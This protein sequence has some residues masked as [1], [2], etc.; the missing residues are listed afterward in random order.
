MSSC[1]TTSTPADPNIKL[2]KPSEEKSIN[3]KPYQ[4]AIGSLMYLMLA[5]RPDITAALTKLSQFAT[6]Y[7]ITHWTAL[8]RIFRYIKGT[9][10]YALTLGGLSGRNGNEIVLSGS[11]DADWAGDAD[12]RRSTTGYIFLLNNHV[13]SWQTH[14]Q[15]SVATSSTQAEYQALSSATKEAIWLRSLLAELDFKQANPTA[16]QQDNQSAIAL[17]NNPTNHKRTKHIDIAHHFVRECKEEKKITL[18]YCPTQNIIAD[19]MTKPLTREKFERCRGN[20]GIMG[21]VE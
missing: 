11:C 9:Q 2:T 8:K 6:S 19:V 7:D 5:T 18:E 12:D 13:I 17:A 14:K 16:I 15:T 1:N 3:D 4:Q 10:Q 21:M 20:M